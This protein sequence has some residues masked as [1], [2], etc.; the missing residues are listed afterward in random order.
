MWQ[1]NAKHSQ[2]HHYCKRMILNKYH[3]ELEYLRLIPSSNR[4]W[5]WGGQAHPDQQPYQMHLCPSKNINSNLRL[6][7][8]KNSTLNIKIDKVSNSYHYTS[9]NEACNT[10]TRDISNLNR[11]RKKISTKLAKRTKYLKLMQLNPK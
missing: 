10:Y 2:N 5:E 11:I 8:K 4:S 7:K 9:H 6:K 1:N 3:S